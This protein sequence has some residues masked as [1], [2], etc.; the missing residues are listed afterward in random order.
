MNTPAMYTHDQA[1]QI[2]AHGLAMLG[3]LSMPAPGTPVQRTAVLIVVGGAQYRVGSHRQFVLLARRLAAAGHPVLR[4]D[5]PGMGDSPG[6]AVPF[7]QT[8]PHIGAAIDAL[9]HATG[10]GHI[11]LWGLCDGAS[12]SLLYLQATRDPRVQGLALL[13]PWVRSEAGLARAHVKHYY[14][15]RLLQPA[16]WRKLWAGGVGLEALRGLGRNL[17]AMR[18]TSTQSL[19]FQELMGLGWQ[20]FEGKTLLMLST[21]DLTAQEFVEY[22]ATQPPWRQALQRPTVTRH[23]IKDADH[24][25]SQPASQQEVETLTL[26]WLGTL[27]Q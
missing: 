24:T 27:A 6:A 17:L 4:F 22:T 21:R 16:F 11:V 9:Q 2:T 15:Q 7:D 8:A 5:L 3:V 26:G 14:R 20:G 13:N 19:S 23:D 25:C 12:A 1:I 10:A 18:H